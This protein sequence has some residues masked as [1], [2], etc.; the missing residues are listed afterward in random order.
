MVHRMTAAQKQQLWESWG[1]KM[2][3]ADRG[4]Y[5]IAPRQ[6][7]IYHF[8]TRGLIPFVRGKGYV[9]NKDAKA[10]TISFLRYLFALYIGDKVIFQNHYSDKEYEEH[11]Q[12]F[13][14]RFD[15][16]ELEP[17]WNRWGTIE[18]FDEDHY[19]A[20]VKAVLPYFIWAS[21]DLESSPAYKSLEKLFDEIE[22]MENAQGFRKET[23]GKDDAYL[24]DS[25]TAY[26]SGYRHK[27]VS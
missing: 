27:D 18:D 24:G 23:K 10:L 19:A 11:F 1:R 17:F 20:K 3:F 6:Q 9:F 2:I 14:D 21:I 25:L 7:V 16:L 4:V 22:E 5:N 12:E 13:E 15:M 8:I 26:S